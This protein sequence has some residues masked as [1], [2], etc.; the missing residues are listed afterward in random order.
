MASGRESSRGSGAG[1]GRGAGKGGAGSAGE[2]EG[3]K[4]RSEEK[5]EDTDR[6]EQRSVAGSVVKKG[7]ERGKE[8]TDRSE[9]RSVARE[10]RSKSAKGMRTRVFSASIPLWMSAEIEPDVLRMGVG[11]HHHGGTQGI[12]MAALSVYLAIPVAERV[13][14]AL[15]AL[16][17]IGEEAMMRARLG[18][19]WPVRLVKTL[20]MLERDVREHEIETLER[21][22]REMEM[23]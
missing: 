12:V 20:G 9:Q 18:R 6:A 11:S 13:E 2:G 22:V 5:S 7:D 4:A 3:R 23:E 17:A 19:L 10:A 21:A 16:P 1:R 14:V 8:D 15:Q